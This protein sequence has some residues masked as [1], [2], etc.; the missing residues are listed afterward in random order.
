MTTT[1]QAQR[2]RRR[3]RIRAV[4]KGTAERPRLAVFKS[5]TAVYAQVID[6]ARGVT[7]A[8]AKG[9]DAQKVGSEVAKAAQGKG[10]TKVVFD[11]GGYLYTGS[12]KALADSARE[13]GL[14]F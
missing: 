5:N 7:L 1:K 10:V 6:D 3:K 14:E 8:A 4:V 13:S 11:R 2:D 12:V 9:K